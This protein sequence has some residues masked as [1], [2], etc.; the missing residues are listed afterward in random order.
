MWFAC[1]PRDLDWK[2]PYVIRNEAELDAPPE[3]VFDVWADIDEWPKW[4]SDIR[5]GTWDTPPPHGAHSRREVVLNLLSVREQ[6]LA[7]DPGRRY[8]FTMT[9][10][11]L[12]LAHSIVEDYQLEALP[13]GRS[14][15]VWEVRFDLRLPFV[16]LSP[17]VRFVFG[18]MFRDAT[19]GLV[20]YVSAASKAA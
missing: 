10:C 7:W 1:I 17:V 11:T 12:P 2:A 13:G 16:P 14:R 5:K 4:F 20:T 15:L 8:A 9:A 6:F 3:R 18:K 19:A